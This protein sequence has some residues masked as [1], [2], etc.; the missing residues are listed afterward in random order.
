MSYVGGLYKKRSPLRCYSIAVFTVAI[1]LLLK[2]LL[3]LAIEQEESSFLLFFAAILAS[4]RYGGMRSGFLATALAAV[5]N[6]YSL[7]IRSIHLQL[8]ALG[9][10]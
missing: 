10:S 5:A 9:K 3:S 7:Y 1:A 2:L 4:A 8:T 6:D